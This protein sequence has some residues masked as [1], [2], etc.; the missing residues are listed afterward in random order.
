[1]KR[2]VFI[3]WLLACVCTVRMDNFTYSYKDAMRCK[4]HICRHGYSYETFYRV[5]ANEMRSINVD[6]HSVFEM[7]IAIQAASNGHIVLSEIPNPGV[8]DPVYEIVVGGGGNKFTELRRNLRRNAKSSVTTPQILSPIELRGFYIKISE[9]GLVEF[10]REGQALPL[11][12]FNDVDPLSVKYFSFAAWN[13]VEAKFL[14]D[15][16][17]PGDTSIEDIPNSHP[18]EP[19]LTPTDKLKRTLLMGRLPSVPPNPVME[20]KLGFKLTSF[21]YNTLDSKLTTTAAVVVSWEDDSMAWNPDKFNGTTNIKLRQGQIWKPSFY[22]LNSDGYGAMDSTN[23]DT[24]SLASSGE[25]TLHF[26]TQTQNYCFDTTTTYSRWP[27]D[28]YQCLIVIEP[29]EAHE[30]IK[31]EI[32]DET[33][34]KF[35]MFSDID[36]VIHNEWQIMT[37]QVTLDSAMWNEII[38]LINSE[39]VLNTHLS[40]KMIITVD[41]AKNPDL[42][43]LVFYVPMLVVL[44]VTVLF[45]LMTA[46]MANVLLISN[47]GEALGKSSAMK[48]VLTCGVVRA[49]FC[50][51][52]M[53]K[54]ANGDYSVQED[55]DSSYIV[56]SRE[57]VEEMERSDKE[58][59]YGDKA[60]LAVVVDKIL[61][62]VYLIVFVGMLAAHY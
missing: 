6:P 48:Q 23:P 59:K 21:R 12:S 26:Q 29:W 28:V 17:I 11:I 47:F 19:K 27:H 10:G 4:E 8:S 57:G 52:S 36:T 2:T 9:D 13:G 60:E 18:E 51:P 20:V 62:V 7:H 5:D 35:E 54:A 56:D 1:M 22:V 49:V 32:L 33:D 50:L 25:A 37:E 15:C 61:F 39:E 44:Y 3:I 34:A 42:Y 46:V 41:L 31:I 58:I 43:N 24:I 53:K 38:D 45:G 40:D 30:N 16:P 55:E 14:Y